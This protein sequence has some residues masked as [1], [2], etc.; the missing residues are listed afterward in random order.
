[1]NPQKGK[2]TI[3]LMEQ[4]SQ[5]SDLASELQENLG[6]AF[7]DLKEAFAPICKNFCLLSYFAPGYKLE[8]HKR[9]KNDNIDPDYPQEIT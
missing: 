5:S 6:A 4:G 8:L 1:M 2:Y 7:Y 3:S 9:I